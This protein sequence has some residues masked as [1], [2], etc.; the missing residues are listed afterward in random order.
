MVVIE[1]LVYGVVCAL[2]Y[3]GC[4]L[5]VEGFIERNKRK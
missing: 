3:A 1:F 2:Y 4:K 5:V